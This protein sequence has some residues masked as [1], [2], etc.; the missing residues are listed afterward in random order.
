MGAAA[1][2]RFVAVGINPAIDRVALID[3]RP[4]DIV[5]ASQA[6][7]SAGGKAIH[8][9][10]VAG[11]LGCDSS[12]ITTAGGSNGR[13]LVD[14]LGSQ[15]LEALIVE[16]A[17]PTRGTYT[18]VS[19]GEG[20]L[21]EVHEPSTPLSVSECNGLV[22]ALEDLPSPPSVVAVGG[23]LP[24][25]APVELPAHLIETAAA[26]GAMTILDCSTPE[27]LSA[28][29]AAGPDVVA[30][31][32]AEAEA[33]LGTEL[34]PDPG[35]AELVAVTSGLRG[36]GAKAVWLSLGSAG[37]VLASAE[38]FLRLS[39]PAPARVV[40]AVGCGDALIGGLAAGL[41]AGLGLRSAAALGVAAA[42]DKLS[43]L[44]P[45]LV[46]RRAVEK[47]VPT[48]EATPLTDGVAV[49]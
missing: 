43:R 16:A 32:L 4:V 6:I 5:A 35:D 7:E 49:A 19:D 3:G 1:S 18:L 26:R 29:L 33:L 36:D 20:D 28:G 44:H 42:T 9:A 47:I 40:N 31:N 37:S 13:L 27:A 11:Q 30:P 39:T 23:S 12:V 14:L 25:G 21:V 22:R 2:A 41:V 10:C 24:P 17:A 45:C 38:G 34:S 15:G 8:A 46:D 48:V